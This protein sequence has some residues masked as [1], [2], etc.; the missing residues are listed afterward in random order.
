MVE[1]LWRA[2]RAGRDTGPRHAE[3]LKDPR[4]WTNL[5]LSFAFLSTACAAHKTYDEVERYCNGYVLEL[6]LG[7][8]DYHRIIQRSALQ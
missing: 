2:S 7:R 6:V 1:H 4:A 8:D 3:A 5:D